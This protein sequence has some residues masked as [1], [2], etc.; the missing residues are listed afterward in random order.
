MS[1]TLLIKMEET[2]HQIIYIV[3]NKYYAL[4]QKLMETLIPLSNVVSIGAQKD[5]SSPTHGNRPIYTHQGMKE[6]HTYA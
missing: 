4:F 6:F 2:K 1:A 3:P 5:Q